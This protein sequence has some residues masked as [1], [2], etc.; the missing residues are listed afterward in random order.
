MILWNYGFVFRVCEDDWALFW[1]DF[2][3]LGVENFVAMD[4]QQTS[5]NRLNVFFYAI[6]L[7][8]K[9]NSFLLA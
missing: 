1:D 2:R 8:F 9:S 6:I 4:S 3:A 7:Y 5:Q